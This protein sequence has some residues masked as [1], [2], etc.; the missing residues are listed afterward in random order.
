[1]LNQAGMLPFFRQGAELRLALIL[2]RAK[3]PDRPPPQYQLVKGTRQGWKNGAFHDLT[4]DE[5]PP[6]PNQPAEPLLVTA[7]REA[8]EEIGLDRGKIIKIYD[9]GVAQSI[10][11]RTGKMERV[12]LYAC[13]LKDSSALAAIAEDHPTTCAFKFFP[14][15]ALAG[16]IREDH[17][18]IVQSACHALKNAF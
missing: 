1:M 14:C 6:S 9:L 8:E 4:T 12:R 18:P 11:T 16:E 13:E 15:H 3:Y 10:K 2:P 7:L 5:L 17:L